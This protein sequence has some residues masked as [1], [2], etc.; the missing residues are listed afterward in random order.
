MWCLAGWAS[1]IARP[2][3]S[4]AASWLVYSNSFDGPTGMT[5][6]EWSSSRITFTNALTPPVSGSLPA[7]VVTNTISPNGA[8]RFLGL[9]GGPPIGTPAVAG[10]NHTRVEQTV[11]LTLTNLG[12]HD[13]LGL[14]FD[15]YI[16]RSWDGDSSRY[17]PDRFKVQIAGGPVLLD[18]TFSNNP[19]TNMDGSYQAYPTSR[20]QPWTGALYTG[21]LGYDRFFKDAIYRLEYRVPHS[22]SRANIQF[23]SSLFEGK[24]TQDEAWGLDNVSVRG[25]D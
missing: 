23:T 13:A 1:L 22:G 10:W 15:L 8:Q 19:K 9:F 24:G 5:Y 4:A 14:K 25:K 16:I 12:A 17:G 3:H 6:A 2:G 7:P 20:S 11:S 18:T 21:T